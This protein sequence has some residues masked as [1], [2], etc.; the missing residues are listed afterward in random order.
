MG[1]TGVISSDYAF[2]M[3]FTSAGVPEPASLVLIGMG[4]MG[5]GVF[6]HRHKT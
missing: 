5:I 2:L 4:L 1:A 3:D 6:R